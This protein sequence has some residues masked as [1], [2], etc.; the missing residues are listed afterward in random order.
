MAFFKAL[1]RA[2]G[3]GGGEDYD[4][5]D[6][7]SAIV[8]PYNRPQET[9]AAHADDSR[10]E[11]RSQAGARQE[12]DEF[13][14]TFFDGIL[15]VFNNAQPDFIKRCLDKEA[16]RR[17]LYD[18]L[19]TSFHEY[20]VSERQRI[21]CETDTDAR[22]ER[23]RFKN[24]I[25]A[26]KEKCK[27]AEGRENDSEQKRLSADR[28]KRALNNKVQE[29][30]MRI[31]TLEAEKEQLDL[32][33]RSLLNKIKVAGVLEGDDKGGAGTASDEEL[34]TLRAQI[35]SLKKESEETAT[36]YKERM[37]MADRML[38]DT[39]NLNVKSN[40]ELEAVKA[41]FEELRKQHDETLEKLRTTGEELDNANATLA[42][43]NDVQEKVARFEEIIGERD[44]RIK[45]LRR[46]KDRQALRI[47][48][49]ERANSLLQEGIDKTMRERA[50]EEARLKKALEE[51]S[52]DNAVKPAEKV[53]RRKKIV[54]KISAIDETLDD[55]QWLVGTPPEGMVAKT[56]AVTSDTDFGYQEPT[57]KTPPE[58]SAQM[59]LF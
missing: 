27:S 19:G 10:D 34:N 54:P 45:D 29:L 9:V 6:A 22:S 51:I 20:L 32:E 48:E 15:E 36:Q 55:T 46:D 26:L 23:D 56:T 50:E 49:L 12:A 3:F 44:R 5:S 39:R 37:A 25:E 17:Y 42:I 41:E 30:E 2:L 38:S 57:R 35:E 28:Q 47:A 33:N 13:P 14:L 11:D 53:R 8:T 24:E 40:K 43:A 1:G 16:Q 7:P 4:D 58:N 52:G 59:S 18:A 31:K 21:K